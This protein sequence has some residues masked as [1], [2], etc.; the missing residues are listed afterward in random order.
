VFKHGCG[1]VWPEWYEP[2]RL[3]ARELDRVSKAEAEDRGRRSHGDCHAGVC[4]MEC[5]SFM[6]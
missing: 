5:G 6:W 3:A 1:A 2:Q 4:R